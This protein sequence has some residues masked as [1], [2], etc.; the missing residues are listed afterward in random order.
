MQSADAIHC[1]IRHVTLEIEKV[2]Y[3]FSDVEV[4]FNNQYTECG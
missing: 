4:I 2:G 1:K 3:V